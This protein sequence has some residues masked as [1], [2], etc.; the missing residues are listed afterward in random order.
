MAFTN[1]FAGG[2]SWGYSDIVNVRWWAG[3]VGS[4]SGEGLIG[5]SICNITLNCVGNFKFV[6][7]LSFHLF[8]FVFLDPPTPSFFVRIRRIS[9]NVRQKLV[10][11]SIL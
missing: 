11:S 8:P 3:I 4:G 5:V 9:S 7:S 6:G 2:F 1:D 10:P